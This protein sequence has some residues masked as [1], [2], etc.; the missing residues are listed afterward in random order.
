MNEKVHSKRAGLGSQ[1]KELG[2]RKGSELDN[3]AGWRPG[4][5]WGREAEAPRN[6]REEVLGT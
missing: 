6:W 5:R 2:Q 1:C 3:R 4:K